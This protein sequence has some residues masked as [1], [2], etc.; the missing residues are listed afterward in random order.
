MYTDSNHYQ[1]ASDHVHNSDIPGTSSQ[2]PTV[3]RP[4]ITTIPCFGCLRL[5]STAMQSFHLKRGQTY[6]T[7]TA[8]MSDPTRVVAHSTI[9]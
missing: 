3:R 1:Y 4:T 2:T 7:G 6:A 5:G 8:Y 9:V